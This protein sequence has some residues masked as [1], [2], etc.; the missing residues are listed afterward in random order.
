MPKERALCFEQIT[1]ILFSQQRKIKI[2]L[3]AAVFAG[4]ECLVVQLSG[5]LVV[6]LL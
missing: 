6:L 3:E 5:E 4:T 1:L 2:S